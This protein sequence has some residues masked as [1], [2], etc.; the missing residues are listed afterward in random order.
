MRKQLTLG[1]KLMASFGALILLVLVV[2]ITSLRVSSDLSSDLDNAVNVIAKMQLLAGQISTATSDMTA[3]E[4]GVAFSTVLQQPDKADA[5]KRQFQESELLVRKRLDE[6]SSLPGSAEIRNELEQLRREQESVRQAHDELVSLLANQQMDL[7]LTEFDAKLLPKL[8]NMSARAKKLVQIQGAHLASVA[9]GAEHKKAQVRWVI[10]FLIALGVVAG[11]AVVVVLRRTTMALRRLTVEISSAAEQVSGA[12]S[13]ISASSQLLAEGAS[14]QAGSLEETSASSQE[15]SSMTQRNAE[16]TRVATSLMSEV[17]KKI[18]EA[19]H[20]L[21]DMV[22]SMKDING[23]SEKIARIIKVIDEI[24]FQTNILA[25]NAAVE[26]ARAGEAGMGF[27]V[28]AD[29]VR[30]LAQ[31]CAVAAKDTASLIEDSISTSNEGTAKLNKL[32]GSITSITESAARV[33]KLVDE[34]N[35]GSQEQAT[36]VEHIANALTQMEQVVQQVA[37]S[38]EESA[39]ASETM[40]DQAHKMSGIVDRLALLVGNSK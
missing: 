36:G 30:N 21:A 6:F 15:M 17:D 7:A 20:T 29:E 1:T 14:R 19:N 24:S 8:N 13:Q 10:S 31:R 3:L 25:L 35:L 34:V 11:I 38:A 33:K 9:Q 12:S 23:S 27:A 40:T 5:F 32:S 2:G 28:V 4:R 22:V 26:A 39:S 37:A 16:N 18:S